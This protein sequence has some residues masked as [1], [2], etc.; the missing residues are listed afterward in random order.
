MFARFVLVV[1][2]V[3]VGAGLFLV[4]LAQKP[5]FLLAAHG[6]AKD[7]QFLAAATAGGAGM[8]GELGGM[9]PSDLEKAAKAMGSGGMPGLGG[10][11]LPPGLSGFGKK[12]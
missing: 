2:N 11:G 1:I 10:G 9:N 12:K 6:A 5:E 7:G 3:A 4:G 8:P